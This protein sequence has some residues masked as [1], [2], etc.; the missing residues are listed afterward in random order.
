MIPLIKRHI[1]EYRRTQA[2]LDK[3][4]A[5][6]EDLPGGYER[7][8]RD[9]MHWL[10][11]QFGR[12]PLQRPIVLPAELLSSFDGT[13]AAARSLFRVLC[14]R[15]DVPVDRVEMR[16][17]P[18][19]AIVKP[20]ATT[21]PGGTP[22]VQCGVPVG[23]WFREDGRS[24]VTITPHLLN[25]PVSLVATLTHELGHE[26]LIG[27]G[28]VRAPRPDL[29]S[30]TDLLTVFYGFGIFAANA[31]LSLQKH[32]S[33]RGKVPVPSGYL[34]QEALALAL[35]HY[36]VLRGERRMPAWK[37]HL[38]FWVRLRMKGRIPQLRSAR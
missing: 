38:D 30:L 4:A 6:L 32:P 31:S 36:C 34:R 22:K 11:D 13:E 26:L 17:G 5:P 16:L 23:R 27:E 20:P 29:E 9:S 37:T 21:E 33:G 35:A 25:S 7:W 8:V 28:R 2:I 12:G 10:V 19:Q 18:L 3:A 15:M 1:D 24:I 14:Q